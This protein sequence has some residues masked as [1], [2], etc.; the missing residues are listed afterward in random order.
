MTAS[1]TSSDLT[2]ADDEVILNWIFHRRRIRH[3]RTITPTSSTEILLVVAAAVASVV[4]RTPL[5]GTGGG[6]TIHSQHARQSN[7]S[8]SCN[9]MLRAEL[10]SG[11]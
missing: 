3:R 11:Q 4:C 1:Q 8:H 5:H 10:K 6:E 7:R 2:V 9:C